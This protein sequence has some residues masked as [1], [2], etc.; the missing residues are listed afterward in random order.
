MNE[1]ERKPSETFT[2]VVGPNGE[3]GMMDETYVD[4]LQST[5]PQP[6]QLALD[7]VLERVACIRVIEGGMRDEQLLGKHTLLEVADPEA[8]V[9]FRQAL[10]I[11][12]GAGG[13]CMCDGEP[14]FE[15]L[16]R[17]NQRLALIGMH[18]GESI[19]WG[20]WKD[21]AR[22]VDGV[23]VL[24]WLAALGLPEPRNEC[25]EM[26]Q[27]QREAQQA[28]NRWVTIMPD[29][30][31]KLPPETWNNMVKWN[32]LQPAMDALA[33]AYPEKTERLLTL[34]G[35][36]GSGAGP[37]DG[38]PAYELVAEQILLQYAANDLI[39]ALKGASL[40]EAEL[41]GAAR[42]FA[43]HSF[44]NPD[45]KLVLKEYSIGFNGMAIFPQPRGEEPAQVPVE[46]R[47]QLFQHCRG[48]EDEG[49]RQSADSAFGA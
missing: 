17:Q 48:S 36:F 41:E 38:F 22:L 20:V 12:D 10:R 29:C 37:W 34:F 5:S 43:G 35:W 45:E 4:Y 42:L 23:Q 44:Q 28:W 46:L 8:I 6:T 21:D 13:H 24:D 18:H 40:V 11:I 15:L 7:A 32:D 25:L 14:T 16:S 26:K 9:G 39:G 3:K 30:L 27:R 1:D 49:K 33:A 19:R 47:Q 31:K 2:A